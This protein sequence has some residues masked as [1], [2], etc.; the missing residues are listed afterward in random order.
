MGRKSSSGWLSMPY[1]SPKWTKE[2]ENSEKEKAQ[3]RGEGAAQ[4]SPEPL[5][6][7]PLLPTTARTSSLSLWR[8]MMVCLSSRGRVPSSKSGSLT[9]ADGCAK[10]ENST[11]AGMR[12]FV[13]TGH[14]Y[15]L[16]SYRWTLGHMDSESNTRGIRRIP[17]AWMI[18]RL[19]GI[20]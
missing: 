1:A 20:G 16:G 18:R 19:Y 2:L 6:S 17:S 14:L 8:M 10:R 4:Y 3:V 11:I 13:L 12:Y 15:C 9:T 5:L 7:L